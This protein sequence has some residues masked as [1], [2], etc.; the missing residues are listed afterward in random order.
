[1][2]NNIYIYKNILSF[3][4]KIKHVYR[5]R[6]FL[7]FLSMF[8]CVNCEYAIE[9]EIFFHIFAHKLKSIVTKMLPKC[10]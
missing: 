6:S 5:L 1:M 7:P 10:I 8:Y 9:M 2:V 4:N 3:F